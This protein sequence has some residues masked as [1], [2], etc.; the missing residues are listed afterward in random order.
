M[1][2]HDRL[3]RLEAEVERQ[4]RQLRDQEDELRRLRGD[5]PSDESIVS[6]RT[7]LRGAG[8][9]A[10]GAVVGAVAAAEPAGAADGGSLLIGVAN[11]NNTPGATTQL[12]G[13]TNGV[14][15]FNV[16]DNTVS[17]G[18]VPN[19][20][21][22]N[23]SGIG[24]VAVRGNASSVTNADG[25]GVLGFSDQSNGVGVVAQSLNGAAV[26]IHD[27][28]GTIP[29]IPPAAGNWTVG[30]LV[31]TGN[32]LWYCY[33]A[34]SATNSQWT[35]LSHTFVPLPSPVRI[36]Y[37]VNAGDP[38]LGNGQERSVTVTNG[39]SIPHGAS[40]VLTNLAV[41]PSGAEGFLAM[42]K[43]GTTWPGTS[44][45]NYPA[46]QFASNNATSA[47]LFTGGVGKVKI[48]CG[49]GAVHFV[50]D[51]FGYYL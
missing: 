46:G 35:R 45:L 37:S 4:R 6:R 18:G 22:G 14:P 48:H 23:V 1:G 27:A 8:V 42:F 10:A 47:V 13:T 16:I 43:D 21:R 38:L 51:V 24:A 7:L 12:S 39:S 5:A 11:T 44:N 15:M 30:S 28:T 29:A 31:V 33:V 26:R 19:A 3:A 20:I 17:G 36:Y 50:I 34:G 32:E 2:N 9:A 49:G 40:A 41:T 25:I